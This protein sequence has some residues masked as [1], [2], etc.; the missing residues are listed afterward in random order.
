VLPFD[1]EPINNK[2]KEKIDQY[3]DMR[4]FAKKLQE[5]ITKAK[6]EYLKNSRTKTVTL[7]KVF[8]IY[9][10][11][12]F[13]HRVYLNLHECKSWKEIIL[14]IVE[15]LAGYRDNYSIES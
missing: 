5:E 7:S 2:F 9:D 15:I 1:P 13:G 6:K 11:D 4:V 10:K 8:T 14:S 3:K 12:C